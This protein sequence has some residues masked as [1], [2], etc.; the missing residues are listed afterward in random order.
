MWVFDATP[1]IYLA[2]VD[3]LDIV[4]C[5]EGPRVI[6]QRVHEEVVEAGLEQGYPDAR[7]IERAIETGR[8]G[9]V[10]V[11]T[12]PLADRL[13]TN[14]NLSD[15]DVAVLAHAAANDGTAVMDETY[16]R[17]VAS[18]EG[19]PTRGTAYLIVKRVRGGEL[20]AAEARETVDAML[21]AGWYCGPDVYSKIIRSIEAAI[22]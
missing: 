6:P 22:E 5:L 3:R 15:A 11:E 8:F 1:L 18:T 9:M 20:G 7:R 13:Q 10:A 16:G 17:D 19:V 12:T 2:R 14:P 21:E 4:E